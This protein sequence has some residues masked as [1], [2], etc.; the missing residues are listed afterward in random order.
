MSISTHF[1]ADRTAGINFF[2]SHGIKTYTS[3]LTDS[4]SIVKN[5]PRA[6]YHFVNDTSFCV[7][8]YCFST[9]YPGEG[10]TKD[11]LVVWFEK[12]KVLYGGCFVKSTENNDIGNIA[13]ANVEAWPKS[14][15]KLMNKFQ[16]PAY[17]IPGHLSWA[18]NKSLAHTLD[19]LKNKPW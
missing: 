16:Q 19:L 5:E 7:G 12:D 2:N 8:G 14:V 13:D 17:I 9:Y 1:H 4:L 6:K 18:S 15:E 11:N 10:H 3:Y